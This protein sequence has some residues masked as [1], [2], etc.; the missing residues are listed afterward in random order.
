MIKSVAVAAGVLSLITAGVQCSSAAAKAPH[1][2]MK[3]HV[4]NHHIMKAHGSKMHA[5]TYECVK[6]HMKYSAALAHKDH[7]K[8]PMDGGKLVPVKAAMGK[9]HGSMDKM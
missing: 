6:C 5:A 8:D 9:M 2:K 7:Y 4:V 1:H 3:S